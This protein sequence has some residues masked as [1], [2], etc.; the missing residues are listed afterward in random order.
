[1][2]L[3]MVSIAV[4]HELRTFLA[5]E[6]IPAGEERQGRHVRSLCR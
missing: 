2:G 4:K 3:K 1:M 5:L 6:W